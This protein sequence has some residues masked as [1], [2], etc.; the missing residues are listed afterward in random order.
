MGKTTSFLYLKENYG[1]TNIVL[2][3][4]LKRMTEVFLADLGYCEDKVRRMVYLD[5][6]EWIIPE[7][8]KTTR[9]LMV[10]LGTVWG[11]EQVHTD[12]WTMIATKNMEPHKFYISDDVRYKNEFDLFGKAGFKLVRIE[13]PR[14]PRI[15]SISEGNLE[16]EVFD[17]YIQNDSDFNSLYYKLEEMIKYFN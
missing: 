13:N 4:T 11:R 6:K 12:V 14:V 16:D 2:A 10:T 9:D 8:G 1:Y 7:I 3:R 17:Y 5:L 15:V